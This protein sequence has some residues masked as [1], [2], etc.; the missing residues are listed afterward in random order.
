[1]QDP[2]MDPGTQNEDISEKHQ[3]NSNKACSLVNN[4]VPMLIS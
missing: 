4:T 1:M 3:Q 2:R